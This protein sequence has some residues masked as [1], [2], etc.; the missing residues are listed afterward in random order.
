MND[1]DI[2]K[3]QAYIHRFYENYGRKELPWRQNYEP[4]HILVSEIM[5][6]QTQVERVIPKFHAFLR[7]FPNLKDLATAPVSEI[8]KHW[9]GL[10][11]NRRVLNL[12]RA[13]QKIST[14]F[15]GVVP[16]TVEE[17]ISLPGIGPYTAAAI[18]AFA[19]N[20]PSVVIE[21][22]IR[23]VFIFHFFHEAY[24]VEDSA[25]LPLIES[26]LDTKNP[27]LW[28]SAL[29]DYGTYLKTVQSNPTRR[30]KTYSK[31]SKL[32]GSNREVRGK[33]LKALT[34]QPHIPI[35]EL[36]KATGI[37]AYRIEK[38]VNQLLKEGFVESTPNRSISLK[39]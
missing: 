7:A 9:Q 30:S 32:L 25:L 21:T 27:R 39:S 34:Q 18:Q 31:Q 5:L 3:F 15:H 29:M 35:T 28:Y 37:E 2:Q 19:F 36:P 10:G 20:Y 1:I 11:Y 12:Q 14:D 8:I 26:T 6:Q 23:S 38:A 4:Y 24:K 16:A 17:L 13:A 22:N 33:I